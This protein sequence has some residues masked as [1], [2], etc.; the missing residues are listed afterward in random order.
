VSETRLSTRAGI[1]RDGGYSEYTTQSTDALVAIP[2]GVDPAEA[3]PMLCAGVTLFNSLRHMDA[4]PGE[5]VAIQGIGGLGHLGV[6]FSKAMGFRTAAIS[7][8]AAK[9]ALAA[10]LGADVYI[11]ASAQDA[12]AELAKLGGAKVIAATAPSADG[13]G[14]LAHGLAVNG[15]LLLLGLVGDVPIPSGAC[16]PRDPGTLALTRDPQASWS[17]SAR[18]CAAGPA[19][20]RRSVA[21]CRMSRASA[22]GLRRAGLAGDDRVR[23]APGRQGDGPALPARKGAGRVRAHV[24]CALPRRHHAARVSARKVISGSR[25]L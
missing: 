13:L 4:K 20:R 1:N 6:Q 12:A 9:R 5:L 22:H 21:S 23:P 8:G 25:R 10:E 2:E 18:P 17:R 16:G 19:A 11:D 15:T 24:V 14:A 7:S 3:A